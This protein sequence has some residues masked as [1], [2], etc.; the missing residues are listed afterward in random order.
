[1]F[2]RGDLYKN[3]LLFNPDDVEY[4]YKNKGPGDKADRDFHPKL[5][6]Q[7]A[8]VDGVV[9]EILGEISVGVLDGGEKI[10]TITN[11]M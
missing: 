10:T 11:W 7:N 4:C 3:A 9:D 1:M 5:G 2:D 8:D 6:I